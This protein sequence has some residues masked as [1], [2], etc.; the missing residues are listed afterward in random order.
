MPVF[1]IY[2]ANRLRLFLPAEV[3]KHSKKPWW[4]SPLGRLFPCWD[5][6]LV[7]QLQ[8]LN[9]ADFIWAWCIKAG[10]PLQVRQSS[11]VNVLKLKEP[12][13]GEPR[14]K[15][16]EKTWLFL[17]VWGVLS[18]Q[19]RLW[20]PSGVFLRCLG[21]CMTEQGTEAV[22]MNIPVCPTSLA[23]SCSAKLHHK[24]PSSQGLVLSLYG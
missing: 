9:L 11:R 20:A 18:R 19:L 23:S 24:S 7:T 22:W 15:W 2:K 4:I 13:S 1:H 8:V 3:I 12:V 10:C 16:N 6:A 14:M 5:R 17:L 21:S